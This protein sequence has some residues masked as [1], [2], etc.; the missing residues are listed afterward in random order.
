MK[1]EILSFESALFVHKLLTCKY[2]KGIQ[3]SYKLFYD[4]YLTSYHKQKT[5]LQK[6]ELAIDIHAYIIFPW[7]VGKVLSI[8]FQNEM[9]RAEEAGYV[10]YLTVA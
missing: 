3:Y 1:A 6:E 5:K 2:M 10:S 9:S 8:K 4:L 7:P